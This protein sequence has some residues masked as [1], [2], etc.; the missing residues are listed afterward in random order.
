MK[1]YRKTVFLKMST[2]LT[3]VTR[4]IACIF[5]FGCISAA[6]SCQKS[7]TAGGSDSKTVES[8]VFSIDPFQVVDDTPDTRVYLSSTSFYWSA[9]DTVGIYPNTGAQ[10][11]FAMTSGAGASSAEFDGGGWAFKESASYYSYYPFIGSIYLN[12]NHIPVSYLGQKQ[13]GTTSTNHIGPYVFLYTDPCPAISG[14]VSFGY[15]HLSCLIRLV[16]NG[17]PAGRYTKLAIT[18]PSNILTT[19]GYYDLMAAA[20]AIVPT[21]QSNQLVIDLED[22]VIQEGNTYTV[23]M[24]SAPIPV[25]G[26]ELTV[27]LLNEQRT[28]YQT[29]KTPGSNFSAGQNRGLTLTGFSAVPQ[30]MGL[31]IDDWGDGDDIGGDAN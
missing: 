19:K 11:F 16:L 5:V 20:P 10:V 7:V 24:M 23:Y 2:K 27:S 18:A 28:E 9:A 3:R 31:I 30:S 21:A 26:V 29:K 6:V 15:H 22:F 17:L 13:T 4:P 25:G 12:R 14:N 1:P 8:V